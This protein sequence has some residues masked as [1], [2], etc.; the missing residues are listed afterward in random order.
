M[1]HAVQLDP[2]PYPYRHLHQG[3]IKNRSQPTILALIQE[4]AKRRFATS[5]AVK[6][7]LAKKKKKEEKEKKKKGKTAEERKG[8]CPRR[9]CIW[10]PIKV[11]C[12]VATTL[13]FSSVPRP[14]HRIRKSHLTREISTVFPLTY[15]LQSLSSRMSFPFSRSRKPR[16]LFL[17]LQL[18]WRMLRGFYDKSYCRPQNSLENGCDILE[19]TLLRRPSFKKHHKPN[20]ILNCVFIS[21]WTCVLNFENRLKRQLHE[22][23]LL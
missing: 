13:L 23:A 9:K 12:H 7:W 8:G 19:Q 6:I 15:H 20:E 2:F 5:N 17:V 4:Y 16:R 11:A 10:P 18:G 3:E 1:K 21:F 14:F 22:Y